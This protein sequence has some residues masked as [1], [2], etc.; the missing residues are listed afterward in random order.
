MRG[1][2]QRPWIAIRERRDGTDSALNHRMAQLVRGGIGAL[3]LLMGWLG[4]AQAEQ[5]VQE[6]SG[7]GHQHLQPFTVRDGWELHWDIAELQ[8]TWNR[9]DALEFSNLYGRLR[10]AE[11]PTADREL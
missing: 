11:L 6:V 1:S 7:K 8:K 2:T 4:S 5:V 3:V 10:G 9:P